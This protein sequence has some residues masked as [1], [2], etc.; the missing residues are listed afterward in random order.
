MPRRP[1]AELVKTS[2]FRELEFY[3]MKDRDG[4][5]I[6]FDL[7]IDLTHTMDFIE[8]YNQDKP[9]DQHLTLFQLFLTACARTIVMRPKL[10]RFV[11]G[12]RLWQRNRIVIAF[13]VNKEKTENGQ[14]V[15]AMIEF[16][17]FDTL[18]I[19][20]KR[21]AEK[22]AEARFGESQNDQ[23]V[24]LIGSLPRFLIKLLFWFGR[25]TDQHNIPIYSLTRDLPMWSSLYVANLGSI[26]IDAAYHHNFELGTTSMFITMGKIH[27]EAILNQE[28]EKTEI[29]KVVDLRITIDDRIASGIYTGPSVY[30]LKELVE[31]PE[32]LLEPPDLTDEQLD[33]LKLKKYKKE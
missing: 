22:I 15:N 8:K 11:S 1:D 25:W 19:T 33:K 30:M 4:S 17:P 13:V 10:N 18:D 7:K 14:E 9:K 31:H 2:K 21:I 26:G 3:I 6:F 24:E 12:K 27:K 5:T 28:T 29:K 23:D 32:P 16:D 20:Q